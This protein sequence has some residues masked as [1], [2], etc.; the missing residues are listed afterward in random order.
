ML[1]SF[2][3]VNVVVLLVSLVV[4]MT[5]HEFMHAYV[6]F[7]LGDTT[8]MVHG[9]V[10][11]NPL[12]HIDPFMTVIL[13][14]FTLLL[15]PH[16]PIM[17][18]KPVPFDPH[19]VRYGEYGAALLALAGPASNLALAIL[20]A[21]LFRTVPLSTFLGQAVL[22]FVQLNVWLAIFN[23]IPIPPLDGSRV[24]YAFAPEALQ[25]FMQQIEPYGFFIII[26]LVL[27]GGAVSLLGYVNQQVLNLLF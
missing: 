9:R 16:R 22:T 5:I 18:A 8:A 24:L 23:L 27:W 26:A 12:H 10:S 25:D 11:F 13:P 6:G 21:V 4:S 2:T 20:G 1:E 17:A 15:P 7:K 14:A 19:N 3:V